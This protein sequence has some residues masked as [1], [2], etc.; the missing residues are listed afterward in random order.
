MYRLISFNEVSRNFTVHFELGISPYF[1]RATSNKTGK[2]VFITNKFVRYLISQ[3][4]YAGSA[5]ESLQVFVCRRFSETAWIFL[6][7]LM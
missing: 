6:K 2:L 1:D 3:H 5:H 4:G 7:R